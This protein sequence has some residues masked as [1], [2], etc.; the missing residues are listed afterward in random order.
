MGG[1]GRTR[2]EFESVNET[3][4]E[5]TFGTSSGRR[6]RGSGL[7][8]RKEEIQNNIHKKKMRD[9]MDSIKIEM[10]RT[11]DIMKGVASDITSSVNN[12]LVYSALSVMDKNSAEY[13]LLV[14][15]LMSKALGTNEMDRDNI[16]RETGGGD[17]GRG[18]SASQGRRNAAGRQSIRRVSGGTRQQENN[19]NP[20]DGAQ[21]E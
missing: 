12:D 10:E 4:E 2:S 14:S 7:K 6:V 9:S 17:N 1:I 3:E 5:D 18:R 13:K 8:R 11:N 19:F 20:Y 21:L 15:N 16:R